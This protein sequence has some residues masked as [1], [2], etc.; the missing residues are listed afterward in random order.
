MM[1]QRME[2]IE[3]E[4]FDETEMDEFG[5]F[6][7]DAASQS[8]GNTQSER[9][10][11]QGQ[12]DRMNALEQRS[13]KKYRDTHVDERRKQAEELHYQR[14]NQKQNASG[15]KVSKRNGTNFK[16]NAQI[17]SQQFQG[18]EVLDINGR[19]SLGEPLVADEGLEETINE[20]NGIRY[21]INSIGQ[22]EFIDDDGNRYI[23]Q[24]FTGPMNTQMR[25][26]QRD[27]LKHEKEIRDGENKSIYQSK[28]E[29]QHKVKLREIANKGSKRQYPYGTNYSQKKE[30]VNLNHNSKNQIKH[31]KVTAEILNKLLKDKTAKEEYLVSQP[32][33]TKRIAKNHEVDRL[34]KDRQYKNIEDGDT[35]KASTKAFLRV[36]EIIA[37]KK[38]PLKSKSTDPREMS[39]IVKEVTER[40]TTYQKEKVTQIKDMN[41]QREQQFA[42]EHQQFKPCK[43][44][45]KIAKSLFK[46]EREYSS[47]VHERLFHKKSSKKT[48]LEVVVA[49]SSFKDT[50][51]SASQSN[52]RHVQADS[53]GVKHTTD[54]SNSISI[55]KRLGIDHILPQKDY[56]KAAA[57][58]K[59]E[60]ERKARKEFESMVKEHNREKREASIN[61]SKFSTGSKMNKSTMSQYSVKNPTKN[62]AKRNNKVSS[63]TKPLPNSNKY[64]YKRL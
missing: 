55:N 31:K 14:Y 22:Q 46:K 35:H 39:K 16:E 38:A 6:E 11:K 50:H 59:I 47:P 8:V 27:Q 19:Q 4:D 48:D 2:E 49:N 13:V 7:E 44:S 33:N 26:A 9:S 51:V 56:N 23:Y 40:M 52:V 17:D 25:A 28:V 18:E 15:E 32:D 3:N 63:Q 24:D 60:E 61:K 10:F 41:N 57:Q 36:S 58:R 64:L 45:E 43:G 62:S 29:E 30:D 5:D 37:E 54:L 42:Q 20:D 53:Y 12:K 1:E 34:Y 21:T